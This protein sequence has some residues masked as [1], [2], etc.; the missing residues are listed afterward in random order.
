MKDRQDLI[1]NKLNY[2]KKSMKNGLERINKY[3]E[4]LEK[5]GS[6]FLVKSVFKPN[7]Q[8]DYLKK[9]GDK[10]RDFAESIKIIKELVEKEKPL[11]VSYD[12]DGYADGYP[13]YDTATCPNCERIFEVDAEEEYKYCPNC[14]QK[15]DWS[16]DES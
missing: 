16:R 4:A 2:F 1:D 9:I 3:Q 14:G 12:Y 7:D 6:I 15:L 5:I 10:T 13:V 8:E 11:T